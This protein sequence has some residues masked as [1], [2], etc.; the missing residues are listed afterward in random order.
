MECN[1]IQEDIDLDEFIILSTKN[2][3]LE[4]II[5]LLSRFEPEMRRQQQGLW[6]E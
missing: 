4:D 1:P 5:V 3:D 6:I 2:Q